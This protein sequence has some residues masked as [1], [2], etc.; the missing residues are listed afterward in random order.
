MAGLF[1]DLVRSA[2]LD[3]P[4]TERPDTG[5]SS[6]R[7]SQQNHQRLIIQIDGPEIPASLLQAWGEDVAEI[8]DARIAGEF[9]D[10]RGAGRRLKGVTD[11]HE[12]RKAR[13]GLLLTR[14]HMYGDLQDALDTGGFWRVRAGGNRIDIE[15]REQDLYSRVPHAE[16]YAKQKVWAGR[17]LYIL[18]KDAQEARRY[19]QDQLRN[20][21]R[22]RAVA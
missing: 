4:D 20:L 1:F 6:V 13:D 15:W 14:G 18:N 5:Q 21:Q 8:T 9:E 7:A 12:Q 10:E 19:I 17:I 16:H 2:I 22:A 3:R 11:E